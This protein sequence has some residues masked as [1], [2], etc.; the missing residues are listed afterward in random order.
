MITRN[1]STLSAARHMKWRVG[2]KVPRNIYAMPYGEPGD[3]DID[4]GRLDSDELAKEAVD[5]H[6]LALE[7]R[8]QLVREEA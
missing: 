3:E 6:N 7:S 5:S 4:I 1:E 2:R 8:A